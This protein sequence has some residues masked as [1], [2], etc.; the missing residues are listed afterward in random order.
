M[1]VNIAGHLTND[2]DKRIRRWLI[3][4]P[5]EYVHTSFSREPNPEPIIGRAN[6]NSI[7][8]IKRALQLC[9]DKDLVSPIDK[10]VAKYTIQMRD[11]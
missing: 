7:L 8:T 9:H 2:A 5:P 11:R 10:G 1:L 3:E 6:L 4:Q